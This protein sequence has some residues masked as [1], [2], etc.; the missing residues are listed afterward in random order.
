V[1]PIPPHRSRSTLADARATSCRAHVKSLR[2]KRQA[3]ERPIVPSFPVLPGNRR[4]QDMLTPWAGSDP[5]ARYHWTRSS[6]RSPATVRYGPCRSVCGMQFEALA[7]RVPTSHQTKPSAGDPHGSSLAGIWRSGESRPALTRRGEPSTR[8]QRGVELLLEVLANTVLTVDN[9]VPRGRHPHG[10][11]EETANRA[12]R[13]RSWRLQGSRGRWSS[14]GPCVCHTDRSAS[15]MGRSHFP[16][17]H[18]TRYLAAPSLS[19]P[20]AGR[21]NCAARPSGI[22]TGCGFLGS[23]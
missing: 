7:Q 4:F 11:P 19:P 13:A 14:G 2:T 6:N 20:L 1:V 22:N 21:S 10:P 23:S 5:P 17:R 8:G 3:P 9:A 16:P 15:R 12:A 18:Q